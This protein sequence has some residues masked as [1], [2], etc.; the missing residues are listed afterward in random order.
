MEE[1]DVIFKKF[2]KNKE[3]KIEKIYNMEGKD[4]KKGKFELK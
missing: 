3:K 1:K 4:L 2:E